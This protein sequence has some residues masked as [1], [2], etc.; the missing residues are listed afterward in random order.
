MS[1]SDNNQN[2]LSSRR[3][4]TGWLRWGSV[5]GG[6][7]LLA[8]LLVLIVRSYAI[9]D[10]NGYDLPDHPVIASDISSGS[11][12]SATP[13]SLSGAASS[14]DVPP[15]ESQAA[16][17]AAVKVGSY[18]LTP[19]QYN[20][21]YVGR[22]NLFLAEDRGFSSLE[23]DRPLNEQF[24]REGM[25]WED[26]FRQTAKDAIVHAYA[27][28]D[29]A[30]KAGWT[31]S[32]NEEQAIKQTVE[33]M[34]AYATGSG[35]TFEAYLSELFGQ[36][37]DE[38]VFL[39]ENRR[40]ALA[41]S[42]E[43][44]L[45]STYE[46]SDGDIERAYAADKRLSEHVSYCLFPL[47]AVYE[48]ENG[49]DSLSDEEKSHGME[50]AKRRAQEMSSKVVDER[51]FN[52]LCLEYADRYSLLNYRADPDFSTYRSVKWEMLKDMPELSDW[53][54]GDRRP[55]DKTLIEGEDFYNVVYFIEGKRGDMSAVNLSLLSFRPSGTYGE[56]MTAGET[57]AAKRAADAAMEAFL[58][59]DRGEEDF[60]RLTDQNPAK[61][62]DVGPGEFS[63]AAEAWFFDS[64]R[65]PGDTTV[66][67][68][69]AAV[70]MFYF[71]GRGETVW[72]IDVKRRLIQEK[73]DADFKEISKG[74]LPVLDVSL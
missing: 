42:Y 33:N 14:L 43:D 60:D 69:K 21:Y 37:V 73:F 71:R 5:L 34:K 20:Y 3:F 63:E 44:H 46:I 65:R 19:A 18:V 39:L 66:I 64:G 59:T 4:K 17:V 56:P 7:F 35:Q 11:G 52:E 8:L 41:K 26:Y 13:A 36:G 16:S 50:E 62:E 30:E 40:E 53:L 22:Y 47:M 55:G 2:A 15:P 68:E 12:L 32:L 38:S 6:F 28:S 31:L 48:D 54:F 27:M 49:D 9:Q 57:A 45:R 23:R 10:P 24:Y 51:S 1:R 61:Y 72:R 67:V 70:Y 74:F 58:K 29:A 25:T